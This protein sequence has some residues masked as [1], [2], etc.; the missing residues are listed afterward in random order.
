M[1]W[2]VIAIVCAIAGFFIGQNK[3]H[4]GLGLVLGLLLG[5][6][7]LII[8]ALLPPA[9]NY[10]AQASAASGPTMGGPQLETARTDNTETRLSRL[11][12]LLASGALTES[13]YQAQRQRII[14]GL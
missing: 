11:D 5:V 9:A 10:V 1:V 3:G 12:A 6:I 8:I 7:G 2:V 4:A 13:E 14:G